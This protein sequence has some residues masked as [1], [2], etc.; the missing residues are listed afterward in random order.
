MFMNN[1]ANGA[2]HGPLDIRTEAFDGTV[3]LSIAGT[4]RAEAADQLRA[5]L[6]VLRPAPGQRVSLRLEGLE[7]CDPPV[8]WELLEFVREARDLGAGVVVESHPDPVVST[9]LRLADVRDDL[10]LHP[11]GIG[12]RN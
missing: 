3:A 6:E 11:D 9:I 7:F 12:S 5:A 2:E 4:A 8:A 10:G 1:P